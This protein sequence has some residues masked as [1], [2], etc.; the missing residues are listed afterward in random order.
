MIISHILRKIVCWYNHVYMIPFSVPSSFWCL[1]K[2]H[3][4]ILP[5]KW[6]VKTGCSGDAQT[7]H[8]TCFCV[9]LYAQHMLLYAC[10]RVRVWAG[11]FC[12][13]ASLWEGLFLQQMFF[14]SVMLARTLSP[15]A[16]Q[17][18]KILTDFDSI[19]LLDNFF[20]LKCMHF[21][22]KHFSSLFFFPPRF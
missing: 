10:R 15:H 4:R 6:H 11:G 13:E 22:R 7:R 5:S 14:R 20:F 19:N 1:E 17:S 21:R 12:G 18:C 9:T 8:I 3:S 16:T 2:E